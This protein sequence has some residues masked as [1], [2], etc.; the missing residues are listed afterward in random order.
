MSRLDKEL[1]EV[2]N[3]SMAITK[4][5]PLKPSNLGVPIMALQIAKANYIEYLRGH[6]NPRQLEVF[7]NLV[8][9]AELDVE[10][11]VEIASNDMSD[12]K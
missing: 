3:L 4:L 6:V 1:V 12:L 9:Q 10:R 2:R 5:L 7:E 11:F 8:R